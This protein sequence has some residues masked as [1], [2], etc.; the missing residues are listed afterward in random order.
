MRNDRPPQ[1]AGS[2]LIDVI[3]AAHL[4][5]VTSFI[6]LSLFALAAVAQPSPQTPEALRVEGNVT[7]AMSLAVDDLKRLP[8]HSI[9]Y[10]SRGE[11][12]PK[13]ANAVPPRRYTGCLLRDLLATAKPTEKGPRELR[14]SYVVASAS[15]GYQAVFSW[16]ELLIS[17]V[18]ES[19]LV[20][21]ARDGAPLDQGEGPIALVAAMDTRPARHVKWLRSIELR[22][23][24]P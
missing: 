13:V 2:G 14:R 10:A 4:Q 12:E 5:T 22:I 6:A 7:Q 17:P 20:A 19:V 15:D 8:V 11:S 18:G 21:Y 3:A 16:A 23:A 9:E 1:Y 24:P